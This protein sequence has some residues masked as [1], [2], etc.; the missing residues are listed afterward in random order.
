MDTRERAAALARGEGRTWEGRGRNPVP[1]EY[2]PA[3]TRS[4]QNQRSGSVV[5]TQD[6]MANGKADAFL[7]SLRLHGVLGRA[8]EDS[9]WKRSAVTSH[10]RRHPE[11]EAMVQEAV[12]EAKE[13]L[14]MEAVDGAMGRWMEPSVHKGEPVFRRDPDTGALMR[15]NPL[16]GEPQ[17]DEERGEY[18]GDP[19]P[20][21]VP[22]RSERMLELLLKARDPAFRERR[23]VTEV[24]VSGG[25]VVGHVGLGELTPEV[26]S[27]LRETLEAAVGA[28]AAVTLEARVVGEAVDPGADDLDDWG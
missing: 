15:G 19:L 26:R 27:R 13:R 9:G 23:S 14:E 20:L 16:T 4:L 22:R 1:F 8:S 28:E 7:A 18:V 12:A 25:A 5:S 10:R 24:Q 17:W 11:F 3:D 2:D 21:L 6:P